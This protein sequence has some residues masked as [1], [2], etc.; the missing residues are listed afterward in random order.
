[1]VRYRVLGVR[2]SSK[3]YE[4][5]VVSHRVVPKSDLNV[6]QNAISGGTRSL[7][8]SSGLDH[9]NSESGISISFYEHYLQLLNFQTSSNRDFLY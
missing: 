4:N 2:D 7:H 9:C 6:R 1:M 5:K 8:E 3:T